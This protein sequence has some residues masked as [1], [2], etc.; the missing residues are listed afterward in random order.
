MAKRKT[1][2]QEVT[3]ANA[4]RNRVLSIECPQC[5]AAPGVRCPKMRASHAA[6]WDAFYEQQAA[7]Q[8][9]T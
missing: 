5:G 6:R 3:E 2:P 7:E 8:P 4:R 1:T 9:A